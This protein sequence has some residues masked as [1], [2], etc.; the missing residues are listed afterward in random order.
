MGSVGSRGRSRGTC[1]GVPSVVTILHIEEAGPVTSVQD[2][3]RFGAQRYGLGTAGALD[4]FSLAVANTIV[5]QAATAA[6][7]EVGPF[8]ARFAAIAG[9][10]LLAVA[11]AER[12]VRA[13]GGDLAL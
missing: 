12:D 6:A 13:S 7:I 2:V 8:P 10:V 1:R 11:G 5:G 9:G 3:G 4:R